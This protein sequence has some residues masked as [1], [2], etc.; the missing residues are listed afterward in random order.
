VTRQRGKKKAGVEDD[1]TAVHGRVARQ[2]IRQWELLEKEEE[3]KKGA[4]TL[5]AAV[6]LLRRRESRALL[7]MAH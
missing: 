7:L 6:D 2:R 1:D 3:E 5:R 4:S